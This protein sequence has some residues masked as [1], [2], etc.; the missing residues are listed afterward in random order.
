MAEYTAA[1]VISF[2]IDDD[3]VG[4]ERAVDAIMKEK[5]ADALA[6]KK[7]EVARNILSP[8]E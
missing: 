1:D 3:A 7:I 2:A 5:I 4:I 8:E 6:A